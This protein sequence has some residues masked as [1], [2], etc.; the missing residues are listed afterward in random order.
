MQLTPDE[1]R[2]ITEYRKLNQ[3]GREDATSYLL[4]L[5]AKNAASQ[6]PTSCRLNKVVNSSRHADEKEII[7]TE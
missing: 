2:L 3:A 6:D 7:I 5:A 1:A 4:S